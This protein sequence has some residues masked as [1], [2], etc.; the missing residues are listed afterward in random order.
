MKTIRMMM[1][2][3]RTVVLAMVVTMHDDDDIM[4]MVMKTTMT[5]TT[6]ATLFWPGWR[7]ISIFK[8]ALSSSS[9]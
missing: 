5:M 9:I 2:S 4:R 8:I 7:L 1:L 6:M 3:M